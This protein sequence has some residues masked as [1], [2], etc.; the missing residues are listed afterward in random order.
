MGQLED[1]YKQSKSFSDYAFKYFDYLHAL[2]KSINKSELEKFLEILITGRDRGSM[3]YILGNGGSATTSSHFVNDLCKYTSSGKDRNFKALCLSDNISWFSA[4][5]NDE[6]YENVFVRQL[7]NFLQKDDIV[8]GIS[9]SGNSENIIKAF[10]FAN[11]NGAV[12][13]ALVGFDGGKMKKIAQACV[14]IHSVKAEYGPVEDFH[15]IL[16]HVISSY[17]TFLSKNKI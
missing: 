10:E 2:L 5:A 16:N 11:K 17:I 9:A 15:L 4:L 3:I 8:I 14:H 13:V 12:S 1:H 6:G 7:E